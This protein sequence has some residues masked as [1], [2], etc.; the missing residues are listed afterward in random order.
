MQGKRYLKKLSL[1][2]AQR[3][4]L[5]HPCIKCFDREE[6]IA[7]LDSLGRIT[8]EPVFARLSS[9]YYHCSAMDGIAVRSKD[10]FGASESSPVRLLKGQFRW[11]DTGDPIPLEF[12]SVIMI[13]NVREI[14][15]QTVEIDAPAF[16]WQHIR[17]AGED[18]VATE[19]LL[20]R[21]H[22][23]RPV[24]IA[25]MLSTGVNLVTVVGKPKVAIIPTGDEIIEPWEEI[26]EGKI[27]DSNTY[28][29]MAMVTEWGG[30]PNRLPIVKDEYEQ[31]RSAILKASHESDIVVLSAGSSAGRG[32]FV[33][34]VIEELGELLVHGVS[35]SPG[36]PT[37]LGFVES[38][39]VLGLPG[40]PVSMIISASLFLMPLIA[41]MLKY[42]VESPRK[43]S[44]KLTKKL[45]S[46]PGDEE[47]VRVKV[48]HGH[49]QVTVFPLSRG[50]SILNSMV[51]ADGIVRVP[52]DAE[53]LP[54]DCEVEIELMK[55]LD[56]IMNSITI[57]GS[58]DIVLDI[59]ADEV[60]LRDPSISL[61]SVHIG[62]LGGLMALKRGEA[63][64]TGTHLLDEETGEYNVPYIKKLLPGRKI[65]LVNLTHRQ[66]GLVV[67][68]GNPKGIRSLNDIAEK[69]F[70]FC[71]R[72]PGSG[73]R[74]LLDHLLKKMNIPTERIKGYD[75]EVYTHMA[76]ASAVASGTADAGLAILSVAKALKLD[77]IPLAEERYDLVIPAES[78]ELSGVR[79]VLEILQSTD[80]KSRIQKLGGYDV[81]D[82]GSI[83]YQT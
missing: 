76:V 31:I 48:V 66:Q 67:R 37:A 58:H 52:A 29:L 7:V 61:S 50:A 63:H 78:M 82:M 15:P 14:D 4:F 24:D 68:P 28:M 53:G 17:V 20:T 42:P 41:K 34:S 10:T 16:P 55:P 8:A 43:I 2:E 73:T 54:Q 30:E 80:F 81:R 75:K 27:I 32:D 40:Y 46:K 36:K 26:S 6:T 11:V 13:E 71:N 19:L 47:F 79:L 5:G 57:V 23:I 51:R 60:K 65:K 49:D 33:P 72:Q 62:S 25:L 1:E 74:V 22:K 38:K 45:A 3:L 9:P 59:L 35:I 21:G 56:Q 70:S 77:F 12:D 64:M 18:I 44:A 39:P 69:G 83:V